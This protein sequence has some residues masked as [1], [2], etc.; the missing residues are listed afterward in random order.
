MDK[1]ELDYKLVVATHPIDVTT[2]KSIDR[3]HGLILTMSK[4]QS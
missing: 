2:T 3:A 1:D 4:H